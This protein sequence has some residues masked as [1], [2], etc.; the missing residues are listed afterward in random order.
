MLNRRDFLKTTTLATAAS[1]FPLICATSKAPKRNLGVALVGLGYYSSAELAPALLEANHCHLAAIV[2][3]SAH[4][5]PEWQKKYGIKDSNVYNYE[6]MHTMAD[7]PNIDVVYVVVP[8]ALH[9]KYAVIAAAAGKRAQT[10][11]EL[12]AA[13]MIAGPVLLTAHRSGPPH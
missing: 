5:I 13:A 9:M 3:G 4:K 10:V 1:A 12:R 11:H 7:N 8:T 6:N 2:T